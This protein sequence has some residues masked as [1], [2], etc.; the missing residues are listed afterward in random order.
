MA[1]QQRPLRRARTAIV[2]ALAVVVFGA[3]TFGAASAP[4][5][6]SG[7]EVEPGGTLRVGLLLDGSFSGHC[8]LRLCG[9][10]FDPQSDSVLPAFG[11]AHCCLMR[12]LL[13][14]NGRSVGEGGTTLQ[15]DLAAELPTVS[16]DG[17][18]WTFHL[19]RG[20]HYAPPMQDTE[21]VAAD[22]VRS[23]ERSLTPATTANQYWYPDMTI[24]GY[25]IGEY[26]PE[27]IDGAGA[28]V[29][30]RAEHVSG[31]EAPDSSTLVVHL[32]KPTGDLGYRL[33]Q[34]Q[35]GPIPANRARLGDPLGVAQGHPG[36]YG[37]FIVS[38]GPYMFEGAESLDFAD[39][40]L[41]QVPDRERDRGSRLGEEPLMVA[42]HRPGP[43]SPTGS[44]RALSRS[45]HRQR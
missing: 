39:P 9:H 34:P 42:S 21:I 10:P 22:V 4:S 33:S 1:N 18:T 41:D 20:L 6:S 38:S 37:D 15:P 2:A 23:I 5:T 19:R 11:L 24:G 35:L 32:T 3:C 40:P 30:G 7:V 25:Y 14:T 17:L 27:V 29:D 26:L 16:P 28:F 8:G 45:G 12:T 43:R 13:A 31:L 36:D 44:D